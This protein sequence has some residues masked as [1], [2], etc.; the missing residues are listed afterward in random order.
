M[1]KIEKHELVTDYEIQTQSDNSNQLVPF[2]HTPVVALSEPHSFLEVVAH[3]DHSL[4]LGSPIFEK[5]FINASHINNSWKEVEVASWLTE[6]GRFCKFFRN[7][8][9]IGKGGFGYV[10]GAWSIFDER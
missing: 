5:R 7:A 4:Q 3:Q 1:R 2:K 10:F 9:L 6:T 8:R